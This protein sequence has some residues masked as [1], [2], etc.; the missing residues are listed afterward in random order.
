MRVPSRK[1]K[2]HVIVKFGKVWIPETRT[3]RSLN[4]SP[5]P[6]LLGMGA[7]TRNV[8]VPYVRT[9]HSPNLPTELKQQRTRH[10]A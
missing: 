9:N 5:I 10:P 4:Q 1:S 2:P 8:I 7:N 3:R 6:A